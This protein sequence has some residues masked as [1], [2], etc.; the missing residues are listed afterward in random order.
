MN[1]LKT[2][3]T[4][5]VLALTTSGCNALLCLLGDSHCQQDEPKPA[6]ESPETP[7]QQR[8]AE[9]K[10]EFEAEI[11]AE[12]AK[13]EAQQAAE[14]ERERAALQAQLEAQEAELHRLRNELEQREAEADRLLQA[15]ADAK[16]QDAKPAMPVKPATSS[17]SRPKDAVAT[18]AKAAKPKPRDARALQKILNKGAK[19]CYWNC[20]VPKLKIKRM[21]GR[22][23]FRLRIDDQGHVQNLSVQNATLKDAEVE[24][25][26]TQIFSQLEFGPG[27][28][29]YATY[30]VVL[31][32]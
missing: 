17:S 29:T 28:A 26:C 23:P 16:A 1:I 4:C 5:L 27:P 7:E 2:V 18:N 31:V 13:M 11:E 24:Q 21:E 12:R 3:S 25:C 6:Q 22:L 19:D 9:I 8:G 32:P 14:R 15:K 10:A 30:P 20:F